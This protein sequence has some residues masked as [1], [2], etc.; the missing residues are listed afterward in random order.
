MRQF[1]LPHVGSHPVGAH[2]A[3]GPFQPLRRQPGRADLVHQP[4]GRPLGQPDDRRRT[5]VWCPHSAGFYRPSQVIRKRRKRKPPFTNSN[6]SLTNQ[7]REKKKKSPFQRY[8]ILLPQHHIMCGNNQ[9]GGALRRGFR[10]AAAAADRAAARFSACFRWKR[11][12]SRRSG[13]L[14][15]SDCRARVSESGPMGMSKYFGTLC[16][17]SRAYDALGGCV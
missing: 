11:S 5:E 1:P 3:W 4:L 13:E 7:S 17:C 6:Y 8:R 2:P 9:A 10:L 14:R 16:P 12:R 15:G